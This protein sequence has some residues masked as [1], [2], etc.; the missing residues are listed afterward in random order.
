MVFCRRTFRV[1]GSVRSIFSLNLLNEYLPLQC[2][3]LDQKLIL[4]EAARKPGWPGCRKSSQGTKV[5]TARSVLLV[6]GIVG[7]LLSYEGARAITSKRAGT[8][9]FLN[10]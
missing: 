9:G 6:P 8:H 4:E 5:Y 7:D 10:R 2:E 1:D 3:I